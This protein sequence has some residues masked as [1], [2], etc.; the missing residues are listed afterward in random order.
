MM[1]HNG[2]K[3]CEREGLQSSQQGLAKLFQSASGPAPAAAAI[4]EHLRRGQLRMASSDMLDKR[5]KDKDDGDKV[6]P[7]VPGNCGGHQL[8]K[9]L[10]NYIIVDVGANLTSKKFSRDLDSVI[11]R[12]K[13]AGE[14]ATGSILKI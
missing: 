7:D 8:L 14:A 9:Q 1:M 5:S 3:T 13:N 11:K 4:P 12:A 10:D 6:M 2:M